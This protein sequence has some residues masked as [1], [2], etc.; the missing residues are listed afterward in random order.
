[1]TDVLLDH[2]H[3]VRAMTRHPDSPAATRLRAAGAEVVYGDLDHPGSIARAAI[4]VDAMFAT[5]TAHKAGPHGE[6]RH[7]QNIAR[8][9]AVASVPHLVYSS[10]DGAAPDSPLP[11]FRV[12]HEVEQHVRSLPIAHTILAP[13]YFMENLFNPWN[14]PGL[15]AGVFPSPISIDRPLQQVAIRDVAQLAT[16]AIER[17]EQFAGLRITIA[18]DALSAEQASQML[19]RVTGREVDAKRIDPET[20]PPGLRALFDW[21]KHTGHHVDL[22][23]LHGR[24]PDI[25]WH[26]YGGWLRSQRARLRELCPREHSGVG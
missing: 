4:G 26:D 6:L 13:V 14:L 21:L 25:G 20:L 17:P 9:A 2:G 19:A 3:I 22:A 5:G 15:R 12:K 23:D 18:S 1:V 24:N 16:L 11:L 8:A 7:G 10:G